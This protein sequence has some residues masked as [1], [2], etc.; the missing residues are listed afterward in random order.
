MTRGLFWL[1]DGFVAQAL[2]PATTIGTLY[3]CTPSTN[4]SRRCLPL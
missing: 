4:N 1:R 2:H 3:V